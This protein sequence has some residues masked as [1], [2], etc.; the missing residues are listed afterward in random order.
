MATIDAYQ[1]TPYLKSVD[2]SWLKNK[3][4]GV[5]RRIRR[6]SMQHR[7]LT[8][9]VFTSGGDSCGTLSINHFHFIFFPLRSH[10]KQCIGF[11]ELPRPVELAGLCV[12]LNHANKEI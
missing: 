3:M 9:A 5:I 4:E 1:E 8:L 11:R 2:K 7:C 10:S 6:G 12:K